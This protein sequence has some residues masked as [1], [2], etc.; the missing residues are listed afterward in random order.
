M[1]EQVVSLKKSHHAGYCDWDKHRIILYPGSLWRFAEL[2]A[3]DGPGRI[4]GFIYA[5]DKIIFHEFLHQ[6]MH[7]L[8]ERPKYCNR[9]EE[10]RCKLCNMTDNLTDYFIPDIEP[11][12]TY[13]PGELFDWMTEQIS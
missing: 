10:G 4:W 3:K 5:L 7:E 11:I 2:F 8:N 6:T 12:R 13:T 9:C 1:Y